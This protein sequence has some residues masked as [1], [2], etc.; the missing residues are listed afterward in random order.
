MVSLNHREEDSGGKMAALSALIW[1]TTRGRF[2]VQE[3]RGR[4]INL[5]QEVQ[6][7]VEFK[8]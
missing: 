7:K 1:E 3:H 6:Q 8:S 2:T 5:H 4:K